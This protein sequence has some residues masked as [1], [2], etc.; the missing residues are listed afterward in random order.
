MLVVG[1]ELGDQRDELVQQ[2]AVAGVGLGLHQELAQRRE[3][4]RHV[5]AHHVLDV[6]HERL[7]Q[8]Q[9][10]VARGL[11]AH[12]ARRLVQH[13][14]VDHAL[15]RDV[16]AHVLGHALQVAQAVVD[17]QVLECRAV[18]QLRLLGHELLVALR[19][20]IINSTNK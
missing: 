3:L 4:Q 2:H 9:Q 12:A 5:L 11:E 1:H 16:A 7:E 14:D 20:V 6:A 13:L 18:G 10:L 19:V 15:Q 8:R 17:G